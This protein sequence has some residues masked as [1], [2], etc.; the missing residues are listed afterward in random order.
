M[1]PNRSGNHSFLCVLSLL[2]CVSVVYV[3]VVSAGGH[4][5]DYHDDDEQVLPVIYGFDDRMEAYEVC[6]CV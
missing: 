1:A 5:D 4:P 2:L 3:R 6:V